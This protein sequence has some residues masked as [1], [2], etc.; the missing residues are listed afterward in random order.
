MLSSEAL[1]LHVRKWVAW[2]EDTP[3]STLPSCRQTL[4]GLKHLRRLYQAATAVREGP[5]HICSSLL[6]EEEPPGPKGRIQVHAPRSSCPPS[7]Q[8]TSQSG[9][10]T[11]TG[12]QTKEKH[13]LS[14]G[15]TN[16]PVRLVLLSEVQKCPSTRNISFSPPCFLWV[17]KHQP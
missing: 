3:R 4:S 11:S 17:C 16:A 7:T 14:R 6:L 2:K 12:T 9:S 1:P 15:P 5:G 13:Q 8:R 10:E